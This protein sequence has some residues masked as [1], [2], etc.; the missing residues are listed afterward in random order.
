MS[1]KTAKVDLDKSEAN[2]E[3][4][5]KTAVQEFVEKTAKEEKNSFN[6]TKRV[7]VVFSENIGD[8]QKGKDYKMGEFLAKSLMN[9]YDGKLKIVAEEDNYSEMRKKATEKK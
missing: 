4:V 3:G 2:K 5:E 8:Y 7:T 6:A 1:E 9:K